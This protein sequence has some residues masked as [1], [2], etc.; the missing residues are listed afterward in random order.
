MM[1]KIIVLP[2]VLFLVAF[3]CTSFTFHLNDADPESVKIG[4]QEWSNANY[5]ERK[6]RNG[7]DIPE[8]KTINEWVMAAKEGKAAWCYYKFDSKYESR[9]GKLY[10]WFAVKDSRNIAPKGW[11]IPSDAE[12]KK[13]I[14]HLGEKNID[15]KMKSKTGWR[16]E[17]NGSNKSG[18]DGKPGGFV[19]H[20]GVF[21]YLGNSG[22]W[23]SSSETDNYLKD[24]N[25][26][27]YQLHYNFQGLSRTDDGYRKGSGVSIRFIKD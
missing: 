3:F 16:D 5:N 15:Q 25:A 17:G 9:F 12:W 24:L 11:H 6:F 26:I 22:H 10:N 18:F 4:K 8:A 21:G 1:K 2:G 20:E 14:D 13:L 23:W 19:S 27:G 7:D